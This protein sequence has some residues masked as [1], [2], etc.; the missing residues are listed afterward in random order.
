MLYTVLWSSPLFHFNIWSVLFSDS[1]QD[2]SRYSEM[3]MDL[4]PVIPVRWT[5]PGSEVVRG[6]M[7]PV[8]TWMTRGK[9]NKGIKRGGS[10][11]WEK[12]ND[13]QSVILV[14]MLTPHCTFT[15]H[16]VFRLHTGWRNAPRGSLQLH[17]T[18]RSP[19]RRFAAPPC[20]KP[21]S[22][23][24]HHSP[25]PTHIQSIISGGYL[26]IFFSTNLI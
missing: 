14:K 17:L 25:M 6:A 23:H 16:H 13:R 22:Q 8:L 10:R 5:W 11:V 2:S 18:H 20:V 3:G 26:S 9:D 7:A 19:G 12:Q 15:F 21:S 4:L 1:G 24:V